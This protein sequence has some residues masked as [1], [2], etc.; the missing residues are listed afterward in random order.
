M[1]LSAAQRPPQLIPPEKRQLLNDS[2]QQLRRRRQAMEAMATQQQQQQQQQPISKSSDESTATMTMT[3]KDQRRDYSELYWLATIVPA[4]LYLI[5]SHTTVFN[6]NHHQAH[7]RRRRGG[8]GLFGLLGGSY[9]VVADMVMVVGGGDG[10]G[11][12]LLA[13]PSDIFYLSGDNM[14]NGGGN[15]DNRDSGGYGGEGGGTTTVT[16]LKLVYPLEA[17]IGSPYSGHNSHPTSSSSSSGGSSDTTNVL[18]KVHSL[19]YQHDPDLGRGYVLLSDSVG[20]G[21]IW[22]WEV[23]G[24][25][26]TI[27]RSLHM[28]RSGCRSGLWT[29]VGDL[30]GDDGDDDAGSNSSRSSRSSTT[31]YV[32]DGKPTGTSCPPNDMLLLFWGEKSNKT[33]PM[34]GSAG[35]AVEFGRDADSF[36]TGRLVVAERGERRIVRIEEDGARTPLVLNVPSP[37]CS[38]SGSGD[39][40]GDDGDAAARTVATSSIRATGDG[41]V[42][43]GPFGDLIF[44]ESTD[45]GNGGDQR[46]SSA[47]YILREAVN[48]KAVPAS[49]SR[50][51]HSW[52]SI[53]QEVAE[54]REAVELLYNGMDVVTDIALGPGGEELFVSGLVGDVSRIVRIPL[55]QEDDDDDDSSDDNEQEDK[56]KEKQNAK[57]TSAFTGKLGFKA[58]PFYDVPARPG[59]QHAGATALT[60]DNEGNVYAT[61]PGRLV[62]IDEKGNNVGSISLNGA[63]VPTAVEIGDDGYLYVSTAS[64]LLRVRVRVGPAKIGTDMVIPPKKESRSNVA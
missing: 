3:K 5:L 18:G 60:L 35:L 8:R 21:R 58:K 6:Q 46:P 28:E 51:A 11:P 39:D 54:E 23:G 41:R 44:T 43:Y 31:T 19:S 24:G 61:Y 27:G 9:D 49:K 25:P 45:C 37:C 47:V 16:T 14:A 59:D 1:S 63:E 7:R 42:L 55:N 53:P 56:E 62:V 52:K 50:E 32:V 57:P 20:S 40:D 36:R 64:S 12:D 15:G 26:I 48:I 2:T 17:V 34:L 22:R 4:F 33:P 29:S 38:G 30:D 10:N 13:R